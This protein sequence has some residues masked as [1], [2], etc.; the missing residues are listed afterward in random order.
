MVN[1]NQ[2]KGDIRRFGENLEV[3]DNN[4]PWTQPVGEDNNVVATEA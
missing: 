3:V 4:Q 2:I 1:L